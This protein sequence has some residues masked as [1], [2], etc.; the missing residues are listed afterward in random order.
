[1]LE[2]YKKNLLGNVCLFLLTRLLILFGYKMSNYFMN[3]SCIFTVTAMGFSEV[4]C[5]PFL[6]QCVR[7]KRVYCG[8]KRMM[9]D[10][11]LKRIHKMILKNFAYSYKTLCNALVIFS[12][13]NSTIRSQWN[14][15]AIWIILQKQYL[16]MCSNFYVS[17]L[18]HSY[19]IFT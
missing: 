15:V 16:F 8:I 11:S 6:R 9:L 1:M 19:A 4:V 18:K 7:F 12:V 3:I 2:N 13:F 17:L 14:F 5:M 10:F